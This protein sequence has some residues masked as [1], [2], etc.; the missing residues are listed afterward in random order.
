ML[1]PLTAQRNP[2]GQLVIGGVALTALA[3]HFGTPLYVFDET[4]V[5]HQAR[6]F[7]RA[8]ETA[9][10]RSRVV[11]AGKAY[12]SPA[13][14][15]LLW[16]E[17]VG[18]DVVSGGELYAGLQAGIPASAMTFHG[19]NKSEQELR[20]AIDAGIGLIAIDNEREIDLLSAL[21]AGR[22][23]T[24]RVLLRLNPGVEAHTHVKIR[25]GVLDSKFGLPIQTGAAETA[26][27]QI[28]ATPGLDL[29]GYHAHIGSQLFEVAAYEETIRVVLDFAASMWHTHGVVPHV[30]SPGGGFGIA[31]EE[32]GEEAPIEEWAARM[33]AA[34]RSGCEERGLPLPELVVEPGRSIIGAAG[35]A[36]YRVGA[37]KDIPGVRRYVSVDGGMADNIRPTLYGARYA[38]TI[39][40]RSG[41][42]P[43]AIVTVAGKFCESGD[44]LLADASLPP[45]DTADLLALPACGAYTLSMASNYNL[46]PRPAAVLVNNGRARQIRRRE[47]YEDVLAMD[48]LPGQHA[49]TLVA[50]ATEIAAL[51]HFDAT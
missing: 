22:E 10:P 38:A 49:D 17:G 7:R 13:I 31:Y 44:L 25:T 15:A 27:A 6:R 18:L 11:Y 21:L 24:V 51:A 50:D 29:V 9:Y 3:D 47:R 37:V 48:I 33:A 35:V 41:E 26:V 42:G 19:N 34:V 28:L 32:G 23:A 4:T 12:L 5:R 36:L 30:L 45:L 43:E 2:D 46:A 8:F 40:N 16:E 39:A 14:V 20:E 1:W